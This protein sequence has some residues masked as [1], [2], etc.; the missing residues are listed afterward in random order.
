M[1]RVCVIGLGPI[2]NRHARILT[3]DPLADLVGVCDILRDRADAR[4]KARDTLVEW[5]GLCPDAKAV[6]SA[7]RQLSMYLN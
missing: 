2:G 5:F 3:E 7:R 1:L 4:G 6:M